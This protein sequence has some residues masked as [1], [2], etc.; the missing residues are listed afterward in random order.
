MSPI[1]EANGAGGG[2]PRDRN[3]KLCE[4]KRKMRER[5]GGDRKVGGTRG[6]KGRFG[7]TTR[8]H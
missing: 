5:R 7:T 4:R 3:G 1:G 2:G 8:L 6:A